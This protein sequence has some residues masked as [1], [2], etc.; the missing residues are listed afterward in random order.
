VTDDD[1][2]ALAKRDWL[3]HEYTKEWAERQAK[4]A[5]V[6]QRQL[7]AACERST[8][9]EVRAMY[10]KWREMAALAVCLQKGFGKS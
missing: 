9:A 1:D 8:D 4:D 6:I 3:A 7:F 5:T 2:K 10:F